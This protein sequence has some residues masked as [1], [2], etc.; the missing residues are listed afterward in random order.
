MH[1]EAHLKDVIW[2]PVWRWR[3]KP[4]KMQLAFLVI[5]VC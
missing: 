1:K 5:K 2:N 4:E 3:C